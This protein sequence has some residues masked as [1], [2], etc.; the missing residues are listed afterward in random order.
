MRILPRIPAAA[1]FFLLVAC[2]SDT[3]ASGDARTVTSD[4]AVGDLSAADNDIA[5]LAV[6]TLAAHLD[7]PVDAISVDT[8]RA[9]D[10]PDSSAGCPQPGE[11]YMQVITPGH[12][13]TLR[14][15]GDFHFV[16]EANGRAIVCERR[17]AVGGVTQQ[18]ELEWAQMAVEARRDLAGRLGVDED[19]VIIAAGEQTTFS[20]SSLGCPEQGVEYAAGDRDG[21]VLRLRHGSRNYTYHTDLDRVIP[22]PPISED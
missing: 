20:D 10:W 16:H 11:A 3:G 8:V 18:L 19:Q 13:I 21:Y 15:D 5:T 6:K 12:R 9:I 1:L 4:G 14:V 17:K 7:V 22:C 2:G